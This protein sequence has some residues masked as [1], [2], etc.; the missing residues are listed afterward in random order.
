M[1]DWDR[2]W[3][4]SLLSM[5]GSVIEE[6]SQTA[7]PT[8][9]V[10]SLVLQS[11]KSLK[12]GNVASNPG[13]PN[14][15][16]IKS[17]FLSN[18]STQTLDTVF[19]TCDTCAHMQQNL[20]DVGTALIALCESHGLESLLARQKKQLQKSSMSVSDVDRWR[21]EQ[22]FDI[23]QISKH[24]V[25]L[26]SKVEAL[27]LELVEAEQSNCILKRQITELRNAKEHLE[28]ERLK[29][30]KDSILRVEK[31]LYEHRRKEIILRDEVQELKSRNIDAEGRVALLKEENREKEEQNHYLGMCNIHI[32]TSVLYS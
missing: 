25:T 17:T 5:P 7:L 21:A 28:M 26:L 20:V 24:M 32:F 19:T 18:V 6:R 31:L 8:F 11:S 1:Q 14:E 27:K 9:K 16:A 2:V 3:G 15:D 22:N 12:V 29:N 23:G 10:S 4:D 13:V 30:E